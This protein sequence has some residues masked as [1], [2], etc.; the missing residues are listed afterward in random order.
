[1]PY[2]VRVLR[3]A[4]A[5]SSLGRRRFDGVVLTSEYD[6]LDVT[7]CTEQKGP[8]CCGKKCYRLYR[9]GGA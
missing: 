6:R 8:E 3:C 1:V 2:D 4:P 9:T 5:V 7:G